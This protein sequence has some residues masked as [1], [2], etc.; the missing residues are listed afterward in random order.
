M[1]TDR[2]ADLISAARADIGMSQSALA[3]AAGMQQPTISAYESGRK[4]PRAQSLER[5]LTA[6]HTRP[7]IP[8]AV[9][10]EDIRHEADRFHL[11]DVRV[12]GSAVR[13]EDTEQSDIDLLVT[14]GPGATLFDLG[15]FADAVEQMTGFAVDVLTDAQVQ[16]PFFRH[17]QDEAVRL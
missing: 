10:A 4:R 17:V 3:C 5:I 11:R 6:A 8:L 1:R 13:G 9:Y 2:A 7:S 16:D 12:F 14:L 15:G